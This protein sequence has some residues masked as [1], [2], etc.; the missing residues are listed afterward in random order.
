MSGKNVANTLDNAPV[1]HIDGGELY[2]LAKNV[3]RLPCNNLSPFTGQSE[4]GI[5]IS[6]DTLRLSNDD[7]LK[8]LTSV[9]AQPHLKLSLRRGGSNVPLRALSAYIRNDDGKARV[10][11]LQEEKGM[12]FSVLL[13]SIEKYGEYF[14]SQN[15]SAIKLSPV[16]FIKP[17]LPSWI[18]SACGKPYPRY[19]RATET[20]RRKCE[21]TNPRAASMSPSCRNRFAKPLS[22]SSVSSGKRFAA[23]I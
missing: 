15:G 16:N 8:A 12:V 18:R 7:D 5:K 14:A 20:T 11:G 3:Y 22:S 10:V 2:Y 9:L 23:W 19:P 6:D 4:I 17:T 13:D 21:S 1:F